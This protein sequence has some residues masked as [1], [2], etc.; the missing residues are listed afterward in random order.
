MDSNEAL[1]CQKFQIKYFGVSE[2]GEKDEKGVL[3][4]P[5]TMKREDFLKIK[6]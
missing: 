4:L 1:L 5:D 2:D 6:E 3:V